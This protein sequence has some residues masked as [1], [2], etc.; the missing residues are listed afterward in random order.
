MA[1]VHKALEVE[2]RIDMED[3]GIEVLWPEVNPHKSNRSLFV[4]GV[5]RPPSANIDMDKKHG[6]NIENAK[7]YN[8]ELVITGDFNVDFMSPDK[9]YKHK[10]MKYLLNLY[11]SQLV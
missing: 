11:F 3:N 7:L 8:K 1:C 2:R 6:S 9:F 5:Y 4:A 10:L